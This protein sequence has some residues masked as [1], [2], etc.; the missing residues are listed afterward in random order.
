MDIRSQHQNKKLALQ[1]LKAQFQV[2]HLEQ[3]KEQ[4]TSTWEQHL[5][6]DRGNPIQVFEGR[7]FKHQKKKKSYASKRQALKNDLKNESWD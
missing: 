6:V 4:A 1:R 7:D 5:R 3:L 2:H